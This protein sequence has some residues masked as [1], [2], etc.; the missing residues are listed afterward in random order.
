MV[1]LQA[2]APIFSNDLGGILKVLSMVASIIVAI[3]GF[4]WF[5]ANRQERQDI[6]AIGAKADALDKRVTGIEVRMA[7]VDTRMGE[8]R[9]AQQSA[10]FESQRG[11]LER[12]N[13]LQNSLTRVEERV[14]SSTEIRD[15]VVEGVRSAVKELMRERE[16]EK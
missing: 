5:L 6:N 10:L 16:R 13:A 8:D 14:C 2:A 15:A 7:T 1:L 9:L 11:I 4:V 12:M 3:G